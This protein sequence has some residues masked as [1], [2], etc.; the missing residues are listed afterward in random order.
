MAFIE[1]SS[2]LERHTEE[3]PDSAS[4]TGA[5]SVGSPMVP[6]ALG[7]GAVSIQT[8]T[9]HS[10]RR[11]RASPSPH[12]TPSTRSTATKTL[13]NPPPARAAQTGC[14]DAGRAQRIVPPSIATI[15]QRCDAPATSA[16]P[17]PVSTPR[18]ATVPAPPAAH[19]TDTGASAPSRPA[20]ASRC[21]GTPDKK[22]AV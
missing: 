20:T 13:S 22:N 14:V 9:G 8:I 2:V 15:A 3:N 17:P 19:P 1:F 5:S 18:P 11:G 16:A 10:P 4:T 7:P 12:S 6:P 21:R